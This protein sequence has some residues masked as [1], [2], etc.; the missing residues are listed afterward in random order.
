[1]SKQNEAHVFS[2]KLDKESVLCP[3][4]LRNATLI[5]HIPFLWHW[6]VSWVSGTDVCSSTT[7][8]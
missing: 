2:F 3:P 1:M 5:F 4:F 7:G 6:L 8:K